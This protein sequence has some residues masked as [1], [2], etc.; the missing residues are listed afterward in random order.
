MIIILIIIG[1]CYATFEIIRDK[2][3]EEFFDF[4]KGAKRIIKRKYVGK[5][6]SRKTRPNRQVKTRHEN[7]IIRETKSQI[8]GK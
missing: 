6:T 8:R 4:T 2:Y 5:H 3:P 1:G 7:Y